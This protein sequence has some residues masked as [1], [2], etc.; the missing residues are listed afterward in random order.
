MTWDQDQVD[1][2]IK[3]Y[4]WTNFEQK[5]C[6]MN[7]RLGVKSAKVWIDQ[8]DT[9]PHMRLPIRIPKIQILGFWIHLPPPNG[10]GSA[11]VGQTYLEVPWETLFGLKLKTYLCE[12][13]LF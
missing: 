11:R 6:C 10:Q 8:M 3:G 9:Q 1:S 12:N 5:S 4:N 2:F 7:N 13:H